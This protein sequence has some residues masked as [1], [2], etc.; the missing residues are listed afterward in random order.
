MERWERERR[1]MEKKLK[2]E[3]RERC[4]PRGGEGGKCLCQAGCCNSQ[5]NQGQEGQGKHRCCVVWC[6]SSGL[7]RLL[8]ISSQYHRVGK[9]PVEFSDGGVAMDGANLHFLNGSCAGGEH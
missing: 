3:L 5:Q 8:H 2:R 9:Q 6:C 4:T 7:H 1:E